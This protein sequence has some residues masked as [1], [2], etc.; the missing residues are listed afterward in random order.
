MK[1]AAAERSIY[2]YN[3][4][5]PPR[6]EVERIIW[7]HVDGQRGTLAITRW[8]EEWILTCVCGELRVTSDMAA[9]VEWPVRHARCEYVTQEELCKRGNH[10]M[11][12]DKFAKQWRCAYCPAVR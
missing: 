12:Y 7:A 6:R 4:R 2:E 3:P 9:P 10:F 8:A 1:A 5:I 11:T